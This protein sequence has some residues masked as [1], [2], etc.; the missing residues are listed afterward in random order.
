M[1]AVSLPLQITSVDSGVACIRSLKREPG[2]AGGLVDIKA[3]FLYGVHSMGECRHQV[4]SQNA[5][6]KR[7][8]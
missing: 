1:S 8:K 3:P 7:Q 6:V 4:K 5:K 2:A